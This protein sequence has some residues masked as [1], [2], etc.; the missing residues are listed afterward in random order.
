MSDN[1]KKISSPKKETKNLKETKTKIEEKN[2][3]RGNHRFGRS[4][5]I[6]IART[7]TD[8]VT[9]MGRPRPQQSLHLP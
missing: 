6:G 4:W 1:E 2:Q 8:G 3:S 7:N 9:D 5:R